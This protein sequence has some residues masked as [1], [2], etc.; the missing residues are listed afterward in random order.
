[1]KK[2]ACSSSINDGKL[3]LKKKKKKKKLVLVTLVK[4]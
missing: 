1:M 2:F 4:R 3:I